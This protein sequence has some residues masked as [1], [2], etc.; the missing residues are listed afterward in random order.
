MS[1]STPPGSRHDFQPMSGLVCRRTSKTTKATTRN[2]SIYTFLHC[3][4]PQKPSRFPNPLLSRIPTQPASNSHVT[5]PHC[6]TIC[7]K[8]AY[9]MSLTSFSKSSKP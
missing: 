8:F 1:S 3:F 2:P 9:F 7:Q 6:L 4:L 5:H